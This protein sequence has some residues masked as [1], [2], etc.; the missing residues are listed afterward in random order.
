MINRP[1]GSVVK[2]PPAN[3]GDVGSLEK[4]ASTPV[5][6]P[7]KYHGQRSLAGC[8]PRGHKESDTT[9]WLNNNK[10]VTKENCVLPN[11]VHHLCDIPEKNAQSKSNFEDMSAK[12]K[13]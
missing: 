9:E 1:G 5:L 12:A 3:A 8:S 7:G 11:M 13:C 10:N 2:N 4:E 6:L